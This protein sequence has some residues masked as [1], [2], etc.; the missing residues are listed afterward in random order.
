MRSH[1]PARTQWGPATAIS[2]IT[3]ATGWRIITR[4]DPAATEQ[5]VQLE[6]VDGNPDCDHVFQGA[7]AVDTIVRLP[8]DCG[9][10]P[11]ARVTRYWTN[12][13]NTPGSPTVAPRA[14]DAQFH[15]LA[16]DTNFTAATPPPNG[17]VSFTLQGLNVKGSNLN[18]ASTSTTPASAHRRRWLSLRGP[19]HIH[20]RNFFGDMLRKLRH[21]TAF[22]KTLKHDL[23]PV[24]F[25]GA[26]NLFKTSAECGANT[27]IPVSSTA[28]LS[29]DVDAAVHAAGQPRCSRH[30]HARPTKDIRVWLDSRPRWQHRRAIQH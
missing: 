13:P 27:A 21:A 29:L 5:E 1:L 3:P 12:Q 22:N 18:G 26:K 23:Q 9:P 19:H 24:D 8:D 20:R 10:M 11:F 30:R 4:C 17:T 25:N 2:D 14:S 15:S 7:G 16:L 6:C 28:S